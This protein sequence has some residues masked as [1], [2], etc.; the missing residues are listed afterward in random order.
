VPLYNAALRE[1]QNSVCLR[2]RIAYV[3]GVQLTVQQGWWATL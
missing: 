3:A 1:R 2:L